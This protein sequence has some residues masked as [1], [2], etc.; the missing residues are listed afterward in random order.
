MSL[1]TSISSPNLSP[2]FLNHL[3][4]LSTWTDNLPFEFF[5]GET[6]L[7]VPTPNPQ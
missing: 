2:K 6:N 7:L 3:V 5:T 1:S 4:D